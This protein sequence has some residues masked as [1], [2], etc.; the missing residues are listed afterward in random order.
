[1]LEGDGDI[2]VDQLGDEDQPQRQRDT[3][4]VGLEVGQQGGDH[5]SIAT[6]AGLAR[7]G[8][9]AGVLVAGRILRVRLVV[10]GC[11]CAYLLLLPRWGDLNPDSGRV[12]NPA[13]G[14]RW[15]NSSINI[16]ELYHLRGAFR[17]LHSLLCS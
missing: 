14:T 3:A 2:E 10:Q 12:A 13:T 11:H 16:K 7:D 6:A 8:H 17:S 4:G 15:R 1:M 9:G 5:G